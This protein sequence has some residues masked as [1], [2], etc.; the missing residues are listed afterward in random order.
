MLEK[1]WKTMVFKSGT[2][3]AIT[4]GIAG[5]F[6]GNASRCLK[7][8]RTLRYI[9]GMAL[10]YP[11]NNAMPCR[12]HEGSANDGPT[13]EALLAGCWEAFRELLSSRRPTLDLLITEVFSLSHFSVEVEKRN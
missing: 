13:T 7:A 9:K 11:E 2:S 12:A 5:N 8:Q 1:T 10:L 4:S 6:R 3:N